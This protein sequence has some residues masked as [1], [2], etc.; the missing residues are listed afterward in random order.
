LP[1]V[2]SLDKATLVYKDGVV[3]L[4]LT[5]NASPLRRLDLYVD[6]S[7]LEARINGQVSAFE[8]IR[9]VRERVRH[10]DE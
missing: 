3:A 7:I 9:I 2:Y 4:C 5:C 6:L 8:G 1:R 10:D